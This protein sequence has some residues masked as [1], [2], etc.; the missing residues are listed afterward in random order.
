MLKVL[1]TWMPNS[2]D[3]S[4]YAYSGHNPKSTCMLVRPGVPRQGVENVGANLITHA[5]PWLTFP[6]QTVRY[7]QD[8]PM[9]GQEPR[10]LTGRGESILK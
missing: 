7:N 3:I 5:F 10:A 4:D 2:W 6:R 9:N 1:A 8:G